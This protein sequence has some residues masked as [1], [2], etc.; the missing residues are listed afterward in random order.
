MSHLTNQQREY[1]LNHL[2]NTHWNNSPMVLIMDFKGN[3]WKVEPWAFGG[4]FDTTKDWFK[5][6]S[7]Y[8]GSSSMRNFAGWN[9]DNGNSIW[10]GHG[11]STTRNLASLNGYDAQLNANYPSRD[12]NSQNYYSEQDRE[13]FKKK[14]GFYSNSDV[15]KHYPPGV[16]IYVD[17]APNYIPG[18]VRVSQDNRDFVTMSRGTGQH[19]IAFILFKKHMNRD[20]YA[21]DII[22]NHSVLMDLIMQEYGIGP[23]D[24]CIEQQILG[25]TTSCDSAFFNNQNNYQSKYLDQYVSG[26][27]EKCKNSTRWSYDATEPC[28]DIIKGNN[29]LLQNK[30]NW[31]INTPGSQCLNQL[32]Y[33]ESGKGYLDYKHMMCSTGRNIVEKK[34]ECG[35]ELTLDKIDYMGNEF[36]L[37]KKIMHYDLLSEWC[38]KGD[39]DT[40]LA[41]SNHFMKRITDLID[42]DKLAAIEAIWEKYYCWGKVNYGLY[43]TIKD[44]LPNEQDTFIKN[45]ASNKSRSARL[46]CLTGETV[47]Y[48]AILLPSQSIQ[49]RN[50]MYSLVMQTDGN[51]VL[52]KSGSP[53]WASVTFNNPNAFMHVTDRITIYSGDGQKRVLW[54]SNSTGKNDTYLVVTDDGRIILRYDSPSTGWITLFQSGFQNK[55]NFDEECTTFSLIHI[56]ILM[57]LVCLGYAF[58]RGRTKKYSY[59]QSNQRGYISRYTRD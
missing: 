44:L 49:S 10:K 37:Y 8:K 51:L 58:Y 11:M 46:I 3:V 36:N 48:N 6:T 31:C 53:V 20:A 30:I 38:S 57:V 23:I 39:A 26:K 33:E 16:S 47:E 9:H 43:D 22:D 54:Q 14:T 40:K 12:A 45:L 1:A 15:R 41:C 29:Q 13:L 19:D 18:Y 4:F 24:K 56:F 50:K 32:L 35:A 7:S 59:E 52:Y 25:R 55:E 27:F 28:N 17:P 2:R 42:A 5:T 34:L 21:S